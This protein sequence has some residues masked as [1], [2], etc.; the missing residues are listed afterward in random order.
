MQDTGTV[1]FQKISV[2]HPKV[3]CQL[4]SDGV[5]GGRILKAKPWKRKYEA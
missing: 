3:G 4:N 2:A 5:G 1:C